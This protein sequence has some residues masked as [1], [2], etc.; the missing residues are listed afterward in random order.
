METEIRAINSDP[1]LST[2][3][4]SVRIQALFRSRYRSKTPETAER[5]PEDLSLK[6][7]S[8]EEKAILGCEHYDRKCRIKA[9]KC[10]DQI[11]TCR[12]CHNEASDHEIDRFAISQMVC[13][14]CA[15]LQDVA[16]TCSNEECGEEM[17]GYFCEI[18]RLFDDRHAEDI[19]HCADCG[20]CRRGKRADFFHCGPCGA[21]IAAEMKS[22]HE[23]IE[24]K[25][26]SDCPICG[27][28]LFT[29][30]RPVHFMKC[31]HSIHGDCLE[32]YM[33]RGN[34][35]CPICLRSMFDDPTLTRNIARY[36]RSIKVPAEYAAWAARVLRNDCLDKF[37]CKFHFAY[38]RCPKC[39]SFNTRMLASGPPESVLKPGECIPEQTEDPDPES[40]E[41]DSGSNQSDSGSGQSDS[42]SGQ[43]D[44]G[45][46]QSDS[47]SDQSDSE[48]NSSDSGSN[49]S[50]SGSNDSEHGSGLVDFV[51]NSRNSDVPSR[52]SEESDHQDSDAP[53]G[54]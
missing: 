8:N 42:G 50:D 53:D 36:V 48:S 35:T 23:C 39:R 24:R 21:C 45:S 22:D 13:M 26:D 6:T 54:S 28:Y 4:K 11:F 46:D 19:F 38:H 20:L 5:V 10:C 40:D 41:N 18:C 34:L 31:G 30:V 52:P 32:K 1:T 33:Q 2:E 3:E 16:R 27:E 7:Y 47:G 29:S 14:A 51:I 15:T 49:Q 37:V 17:A 25:M 9:G 12:L 44:S 43:S